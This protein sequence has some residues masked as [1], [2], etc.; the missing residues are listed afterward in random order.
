M[1]LIRT[2]RWREILGALIMVAVLSPLAIGLPALA[3]D[4]S[5]VLEALGVLQQYYVDRIDPVKM[6]NAALAGSEER[7]VGKECVRLCR[8]RWSP[9]H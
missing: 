1:K 3:A 4:Q 6:L 9:Y 7:R 2:H 8:S 5:L